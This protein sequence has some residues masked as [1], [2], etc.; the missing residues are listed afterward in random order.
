[1]SCHLHCMTRTFRHEATCS[2]G[3]WKYGVRP[4][5]YVRTSHATAQTAVQCL[6][7]SDRECRRL[8]IPC[9]PLCA[10]VC[11]HKR[12]FLS[13]V[14]DFRLI[15]QCA[16]TRLGMGPSPCKRRATPANER[17]HMGKYPNAVGPRR[18]PS[19]TGRA[20]ENSTLVYVKTLVQ[21]AFRWM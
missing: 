2:L 1:M 15:H 14:H 21:R 4:Q 6:L 11:C 9:S 12:A 10:P 5:V 8:H 17:L 13:K 20:R 7:P 3:I 16:C 19:K 18:A